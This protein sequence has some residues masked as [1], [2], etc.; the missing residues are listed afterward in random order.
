MHYSFPLNY[1]NFD[2]F[3]ISDINNVLILELWLIYPTASLTSLLEC[4]IT[5]TKLACPK[6]KSSSTCPSPNVPYFTK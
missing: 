2:A 3:K 5:I 1:V 6:P 4:S